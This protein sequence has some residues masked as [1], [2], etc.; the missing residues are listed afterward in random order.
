M[1]PEVELKEPEHDTNQSS[2]TKQADDDVVV[3]RRRHRVHP[4]QAMSSNVIMHTGDAICLPS[5][6]VIKVN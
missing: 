1:E 4:I 3:P 6:T 2:S 5:E